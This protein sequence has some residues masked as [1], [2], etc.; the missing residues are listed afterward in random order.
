MHTKPRS[1]GVFSLTRDRRVAATGVGWQRKWQ[2]EVC[3]TGFREAPTDFLLAPFNAV[4]TRLYVSVDDEGR[5]H[6]SSPG[7]S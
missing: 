4:A 5:L 3:S 1:G 7:D 6:A 2:P